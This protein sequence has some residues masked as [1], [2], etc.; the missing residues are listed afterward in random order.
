LA[1]PWGCI[2]LRPLLLLDCLP[3]YDRWRHALAVEPSNDDWGILA[4]SIGAVIDHQSEASTDIRW[5]KLILPVISGRMRFPEAQSERLDE[6]RL[7]PDKGDMRSVRPFIRSGEMVLRRNPP[8]PWVDAFWTLAKNKTEC[9]EPSK[10]DGDTFIDTEIN[11]I[12]LYEVRDE[13]IE[14]F[15]SNASPL[16]IDPKLDSALVLRCMV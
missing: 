9:M 4:R 12:S 1:H 6:L 3:G 13:V 11:P 8:S 2:A 10:G 15:H 5:F 14:R 16:R 7:F